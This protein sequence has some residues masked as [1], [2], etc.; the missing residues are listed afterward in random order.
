L[1]VH[2]SEIRAVAHQSSG[3]GEFGPPVYRRQSALRS[4][5]HDLRSSSVDEQVVQRDESAGVPSRGGPKSALEIL[6]TA[7][8]QQLKLHAQGLG[9]ELGR[10]ELGGV[11]WI[12]R[13]PKDGHPG[14]S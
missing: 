6:R 3:L 2:V 4:K 5:R 7:N 12:G 8:L 1:S 14:D 11:A 10:P 13:I 9:H